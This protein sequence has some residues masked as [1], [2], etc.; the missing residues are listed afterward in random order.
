MGS[1]NELVMRRPMDLINLH[2]SEGS[3]FLLE[4]HF[5]EF[6]LRIQEVVIRVAL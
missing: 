1:S 2:L 4:D 5:K 6:R 3:P